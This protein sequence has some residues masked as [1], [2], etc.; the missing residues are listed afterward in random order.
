MGSIL[1]A[2]ICKRPAW[3]SL[4]QPRL[5]ADVDAGTRHSKNRTTRTDKV[6]NFP[7]QQHAS[8]HRDWPRCRSIPFGAVME[9]ESR[10]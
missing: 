6:S 1:V 3:T 10:A 9:S 5:D 2:S 8:N 4:R 7:A